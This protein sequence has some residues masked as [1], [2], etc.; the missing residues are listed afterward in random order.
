MISPEEGLGLRIKNRKKPNRSG[1]SLYTTHLSGGAF[2]RTKGKRFKAREGG[3]NKRAGRKPG[4][5]KGRYENAI[6]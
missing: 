1:P 2:R 5:Q 6:E 4:L 3:E